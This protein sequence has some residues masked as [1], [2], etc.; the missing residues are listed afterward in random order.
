MLLREEHD[1]GA[2]RS[3]EPSLDDWLRGRALANMVLGASRT[4]VSCQTGTR[5]VVG[6]YALSMGQI[7]NQE[8]IGSVRRNMPRFIPAVV[9]GRLAVDENWQRNGL[10]AALLKDA[11]LRSLRAAEEVSA[12]L[13]VVHAIS[14]A[15]E[16]F[17]L[18]H[19]FSRLPV[20]TPTYA[21]DLVKFARI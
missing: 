2:F 18:R 13:V 11:V 6:F 14:P 8:A 20:D 21:L 3:G 1:I 4:F 9:L 16:A 5:R 10:G 12:R 7:L 19:G 17:Y 15:A